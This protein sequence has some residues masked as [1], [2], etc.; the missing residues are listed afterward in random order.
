MSN[1][2]LIF[3]FVKS[4]IKLNN[5]LINMYICIMQCLYLKISPNFSEASII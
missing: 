2:E 1:Q 5:Y 4:R 3:F